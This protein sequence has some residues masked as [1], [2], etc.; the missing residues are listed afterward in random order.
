MKNLLKLSVVL[1][2]TLLC[3][4]TAHASSGPT[5]FLGPTLQG[6]YTGNINNNSAYSLLGEA[7]VKNFRVGGTL[8]WKAEENQY[9]KLSA[10]YL[11]QD[12]TY[13]FITGNSNQWMSQ[14]ALGA[15]YLYEFAGNYQP[16]FDLNA[17]VS[18]APSKSLSAVNGTTIVA[19]VLNNF[20]V[21]RRIAGSN[22]AGI[23]PALSIA[24]WQGGR[25][26]VGLNYDNV[27]YD[28]NYSPNEDAKG[29]GGTATFDQK[30][31]QTVDFGLSAAVRQPFNNYAANVSFSNPAFNNWVLGVGGDYTTGKN[32]LP[33]TWDVLFSASYSFDKR[34]VSAPAAYKGFK[35]ETAM[36]VHDDLMSYTADPAVYMP[37]VLAVTD[38]REITSC[39]YGQPTFTGTIANQT[40]A[41][42]VTQT[43]NSPTSFG[44]TGLTYTVVSSKTGG[45]TSTVTINST[46][47]AVTVT[48]LRSTTTITITAT[49]PC[50]AR[51]SSNAF[52]ATFT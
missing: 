48:G 12:I 41:P 29:F 15:G 3:L 14:G 17:Y 21:Q 9:L 27:R 38:Q 13:S 37:Q 43:F 40:T 4:S 30:L 11:T 33:N 10:E 32:T 20:T 1:C 50:G 2:S 51:V 19:G 31:S 42:G 35:G 24:P 23:V 7:G 47:G 8:G 39:A 46:T 49:N 28:K 18:H 6:S 45:G 25:V 34:T 36:P 52:T 5:T 26:G 22:A 16:H 44:G